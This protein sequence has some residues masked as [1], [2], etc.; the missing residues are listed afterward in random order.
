MGNGR[1]Y[2]TSGHTGK[3]LAV[4]ADAKPDATGMLTRDAIAWEVGKGVVPSRPSVLLDGELLYMVSDGGIATC[5]E[6]ATGKVVWSE[7]LGGDEFSASPVLANGRL[8]FCS[9]GGRTFVVDA[10]RTFN[11]SENRLD[12]RIMASPAVVGTQLYLRTNTN[13]YSIGKR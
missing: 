4:K 7:R 6:T 11:V 8:Y 3:L 9:H 5:L 13:L 1:L 2:L 12:G 10:R